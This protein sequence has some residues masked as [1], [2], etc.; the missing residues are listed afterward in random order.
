MKKGL[1]ELVFIIDRSGSMGGLESDTIGGFNAMLKEQQAV[2]GDAVVT[3]V[4][5]DDKYEL[6]HDRIDIR[7]VASLTDKD[8]TVRETTALLDA[9]GRTIHKIRAVQKH[10]ANNY[11]AEK[12]LFVIITDGQENASREYS[13]ERIKRRIER[14]KERYG[15]EF[16]FFG[17]NMDAV[18]EAGKLGIAADHAQNYCADAIGTSVAYAAMSAFSTAY[19]GGKPFNGLDTSVKSEN[20]SSDCVTHDELKATLAKLKAAVGG[21]KGAADDLVDVFGDIFEVAEANNGKIP[22]VN[23]IAR[24]VLEDELKA[25]EANSGDEAR[26]NE[27]RNILK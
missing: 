12:V 6:L 25:L 20:N 17:A 13:A 16:V 10:T 27:L 21:A 24:Q 2:E 14:Q 19:R 23:D 7:A 5:F 26:I 8:Y 9:L 18:M 22:D 15:W 11:R 4:L 3:T 1:T